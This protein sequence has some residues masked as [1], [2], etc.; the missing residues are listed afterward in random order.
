MIDCCRKSKTAEGESDMKGHCFAAGILMIAGMILSAGENLLKN[1]DFS[2]GTRFWNANF[3]MD[4][5][6]NALL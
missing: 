4:A 2:R 3:T 1:G 5:K 6:E